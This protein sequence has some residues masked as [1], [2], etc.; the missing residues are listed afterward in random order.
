MFRRRPSPTVS[1]VTELTELR[2]EVLTE[3]HPFAAQKA[4]SLNGRQLLS[5]SWDTRAGALTLEVPDAV[6]TVVLCDDGAVAAQIA[7]MW[8]LEETRITATAI[9]GVLHIEAWSAS[10]HYHL[11]GIP[12][13]Q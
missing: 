9:S 8:R 12:A 6:N 4:G 3:R 7:T 10:W 2:R 11:A 5:S 1:F 13:G